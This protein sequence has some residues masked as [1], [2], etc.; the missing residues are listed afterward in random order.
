MFRQIALFAV[1]QFPYLLNDIENVK[2]TTTS[3]ADFMK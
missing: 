3:P 2:N 1:P